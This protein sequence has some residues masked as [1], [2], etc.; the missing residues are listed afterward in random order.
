MHF[1]LEVTTRLD[2]LSLFYFASGNF[3]ELA[4][5]GLLASAPEPFDPMHVAGLP[6]KA[7]NFIVADDGAPILADNYAARLLD[8]DAITF[9]HLLSGAAY[10][11]K[12]SRTVLRRRRHEGALRLRRGGSRW[13][14]R[15][16]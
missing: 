11:V 15:W 14:G 8:H 9:A 12:A 6:A 2:E 1:G 4:I 16:L 7:I 5:Y 3:Q 13:R 10:V